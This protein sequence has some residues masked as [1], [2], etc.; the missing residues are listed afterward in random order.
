[1]VP[2]NPRVV[3]LIVLA[4][5]AV[6]ALIVWWM[7]RSA[8]VRRKDFRRVQLERDYAVR[9]LHE[10]SQYVDV[11][12][13]IDSLLAAAVRPSITEFNQNRMELYK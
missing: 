5:V 2:L 7:S 8:G 6:A 11:Y 9:A 13:D 10:I 4:A 3:L 1:V 12:R